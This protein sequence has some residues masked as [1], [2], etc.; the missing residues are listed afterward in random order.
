MTIE[1]YEPT[2]TMPGVPLITYAVSHGDTVHLAGV[3]AD[4]RAPGDVAQQTRQILA[5][6]DALLAAAGSHKSKLLSAQVWLTDMALYAAHN[7][8]WNEWVDRDNP[9]VRACLLSPQ[10]WRPG[11]LVEIMAT[12]AR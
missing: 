9:P 4:P 12:A 3:T 10:L 6:I 1:R 11:L 7:D 5:R 8:A 2:P